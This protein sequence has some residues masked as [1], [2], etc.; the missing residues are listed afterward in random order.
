MKRL[1]DLILAVCAVL[2]LALPLVL[3]ALLAKL[4]SKGQVFLLV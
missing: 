1:F 2:I 3:L 4:S